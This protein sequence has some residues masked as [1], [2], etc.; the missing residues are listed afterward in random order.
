MLNVSC[1]KC[2]ASVTVTAIAAAA[3]PDAALTCACCPED[4]H[5][6]RAANE[7]GAACRPITINVGQVAVGPAGGN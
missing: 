2:G 5:H 6:G 7:S 4:H 3:D 1:N